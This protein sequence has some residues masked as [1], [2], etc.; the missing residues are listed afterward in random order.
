MHNPLIEPASS[1]RHNGSSVSQQKFA[2]SLSLIV[3]FLMLA[4]KT[5]A[6]AI[7]GSAAILSDAAESVVHVFAVAFAAFSLW[8][9]L[10]PPDTSHPYGHEKISFFSAGMEGMM[11]VLAAIFIIYEAIQKWLGGMELQNLGTGTVYTAAATAINAAL[12]GYLVWQGKRHKSIILIAN[13]KHVLTDSWTSF[14]V[15]VG[16]LLTIW[17]GWLPFDP[18]LAILVAFNILWSGSKLLRQSVGGLMDEGDPELE[19][20]LRALLDAETQ[21]RGLWYHEL[22][23]RQSGASLWVE[24]HLLFPRGEMIEDAHR[25]ATE[26]EAAVKQAFSLPVNIITHLEPREGHDEIHQKIKAAKD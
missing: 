14:G 25:K 10:K 24:A 21:K 26:I 9:S 16:L 22:R 3:G 7:T 6:Y 4:G 13:G 8:L 12:G 5:Y 23:Y 19:R 15:I 1:S 11:I 20:Q 2:I 17:T 18:I